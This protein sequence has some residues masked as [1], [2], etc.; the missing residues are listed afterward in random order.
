MIV[1]LKPPKKL[2]PLNKVAQLVAKAEILA[3]PLLC[4]SILQ[5]KIKIKIKIEIQNG[6]WK[7]FFLA[8]KAKL[9][10]I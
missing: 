3:L 7:H 8:T 10:D 1:L 6:K 2:A 5:T 9:L 4:E